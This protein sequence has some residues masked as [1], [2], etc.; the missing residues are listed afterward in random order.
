MKAMKLG[1]KAF[2]YHSNCKVPGIAGYLLQNIS[3]HRD[4]GDIERGIS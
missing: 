4:N 1:D 2:F 3:N